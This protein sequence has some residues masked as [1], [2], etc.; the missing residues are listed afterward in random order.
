MDD[1]TLQ[2]LQTVFAAN[3]TQD[4]AQIIALQ[5]VE[6]ADFNAVVNYL[7]YLTSTI[8]GE[9]GKRLGEVALQVGSY[10]SALQ[11]LNPEEPSHLQLIIRRKLELGDLETAQE[12][13]KIC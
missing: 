1:K 8:E 11:F 13:Y 10:Q 6:S 12:L 2:K 7:S 9:D 4:L 5:L 3:P